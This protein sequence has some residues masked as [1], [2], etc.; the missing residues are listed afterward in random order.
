MPMQK[1]KSMPNP[2]QGASAMRESERRTGEQAEE[3]GTWRHPGK[4]TAHMANED[5]MVEQMPNKV[6]APC[7][8]AGERRRGGRRAA[9]DW[10]QRET[11]AGQLRG[12][13]LL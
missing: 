9:T 12:D 1:A 5:R 10:A 7:E 11:A 4:R 2:M 3:Y 13:A 6:R 8:R